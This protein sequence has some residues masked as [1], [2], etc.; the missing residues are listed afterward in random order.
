MSY[1]LQVWDSN[2]TK[3][4]DTTTSFTRVLG[5]LTIPTSNGS[6]T[7]ARLSLGNPFFAISGRRMASF[8]QQEYPYIRIV[9][10]T[11]IWSYLNPDNKLG[12]SIVYG[13]FS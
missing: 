1:G 4:V 10:N 2:S 6:Y 8:V 5:E 11:I 7:D 12:T 3:T 9:G 13:V